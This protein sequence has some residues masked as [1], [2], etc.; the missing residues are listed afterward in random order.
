LVDLL[1]IESLERDNIDQRL[2]VRTPPAE[3]D[4]RRA[5]LALMPRLRRHRLGQRRDWYS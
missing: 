3:D 5:A 1:R 4:I 2:C